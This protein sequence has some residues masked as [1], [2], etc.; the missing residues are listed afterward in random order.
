MKH[1]IDLYLQ[2]KN[3]YAI[4]IFRIIIMKY[5]MYWDETHAE[6]SMALPA[7]KKI[8]HGTKYSSSPLSQPVYAEL[9]P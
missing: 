4:Y 2:F 3:I 9:T 7:K 5:E 6:G 1:H 8:S